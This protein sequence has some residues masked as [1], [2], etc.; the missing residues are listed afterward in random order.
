MADPQAY[1][2]NRPSRDRLASYDSRADLLHPEENAKVQH[3][4]CTETQYLGFSIPE[5]DIHALNYIWHHP[6]M[7][8]VMGGTLIF[9]GFKPMTLAA[10]LIDMRQY[11]SDA[12]LA[13]DL[14]DYTLDNGYRAR[15]LEPLKRFRVSYTDA[16]RNNA[17]DVELEA[18]MPLAMWSTGRHFEQACKTKGELLLR[19]KRY[20]FNGYTIRDRSWGEARME[21]QAR[22]PGTTWMTGTFSEHFA[23]NCNAIDHPDGNP[24]WK[25]SFRIT[26]DD[27]LLGGWVWANGKISPIVK[28]RKVI[29][30]DRRTLFPT[31]VE[32]AITTVDGGEYELQGKVKAACPFNPWMNCYTPICLVEWSCKGQVGWGEAQDIQW[33][34]F[35]TEYARS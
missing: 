31:Q 23:F 15:V 16:Q 7:Q 35:V 30:R 19:G 21:D 26:G 24:L 11:M 22:I 6:K 33:N 34:D 27:A 9:Q 12:S 10:E 3:Y 17:F 32:L 29:P 14:H 28:A 13:N 20:Q 2:L 25:D 18:V 8:T 5:A 4:A 1:F